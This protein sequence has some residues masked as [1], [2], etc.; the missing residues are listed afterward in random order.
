MQKQDRKKNRTQG[1]IAVVSILLFALALVIAVVVVVRS[2]T[3]I[4]PVPVPK[5]LEQSEPDT[6]LV[7]FRAGMRRRLG[8][9]ERR[10]CGFRDTAGSYTPEQESLMKVCD[11]GL[12]LIRDELEVLDTLTGG[13]QRVAF[14][15]T[16]KQEYVDLKMSVYRFTKLSLQAE[17]EPDLDSLD[18]ELQRLLDLQP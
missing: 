17:P 15:Q 14:A 12:V 3:R 10:F 7:R 6:G 13:R 18:L 1:A 9:L 5:G 16:V 2:A 11:S 4:R 8:K